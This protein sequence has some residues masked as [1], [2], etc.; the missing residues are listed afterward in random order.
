MNESANR[1]TGCRM[2]IWA[3]V[4]SFE[5]GEPDYLRANRA[6]WD[7]RARLHVASPDYRVVDFEDPDFLSDVVRFDLPRLGDVTG[8]R[9]IHLQCHIGTDTISLSRLG[10]Q[11]TGLDLSP[12]SISQATKLSTRFAAAIDWVVSDVYDAPV[13]LSRA[14]LPDRGYDLVYVSLGALNWL[15]SVARWAEVVAGL[16]RP[17][18]RLFIRDVHP[19]LGSLDYQRNDG[20][21]VIDQAYFE[22]AGA[23][24]I[25]EPN[26]YVSTSRPLTATVSHQWNHAIGDLL[27]AVIEAGLRLTMFVEHDSAPFPALG[28]QVESVGDGEFR[29]RDRPERLPQSFTLQAV[30]P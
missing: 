17:G 27:S 11:M 3:D 25:D 9:G 4:S 28:D 12:E 18:G 5:D 16:L 20:L 23:E 8:L 15:P 19:L 22:V 30:K 21:L 26:S 2:A 10:A 7:D 13:A 6:N 24:I 14:G 29:L 1:Q